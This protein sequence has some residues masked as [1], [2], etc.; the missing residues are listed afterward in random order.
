MKQLMKSV[1]GVSLSLVVLLGTTQTSHASTA[2]T[3]QDASRKIHGITSKNFSTHVW[4]TII[5]QYSYKR[6]FKRRDNGRWIQYKVHGIIV[7]AQRCGFGPDHHCKGPAVER[8]IYSSRQ[9]GV[10]THNHVTLSTNGGKSDFCLSPGSTNCAA[11]WNWINAKVDTGLQNT[12]KYVVKPCAKGT[13]SALGVNAVGHLSAKAAAEGATDATAKKVIG[14]FGPEAAV[15]W[16]IGGCA[17]GEKDGAI[18][19]AKKLG[20]KLFGGIFKN[21]TWTG[22]RRSGVQ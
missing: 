18:S 17:W 4:T 7:S 21:G 6:W 16:G 10:R 5:G 19:A 20:E 15:A 11:P 1:V 3:V 2:D 9:K 12:V 8:R 13:A 14:F 22:A